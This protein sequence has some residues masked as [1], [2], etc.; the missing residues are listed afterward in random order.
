MTLESQ[1]ASLAGR[2]ITSL[3]HAALTANFA[4]KEATFFSE[5]CHL[6]T[7]TQIRYSL[8]KPNHFFLMRSDMLQLLHKTVSE[9]DPFLATFSAL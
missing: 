2:L 3:A 8:T 9:P 4:F 7:P 5:D 1:Q 6:L